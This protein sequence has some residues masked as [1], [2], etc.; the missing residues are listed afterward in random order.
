MI[1]PKAA[2]QADALKQFLNWA[3]DRGQIYG[4]DLYFMPIPKVVQTE[5]L[6][7]VNQIQQAS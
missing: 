2:K 1:A 5:S 6:K 7:L 3:L 4:N